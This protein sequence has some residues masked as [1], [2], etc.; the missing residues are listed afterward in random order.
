MAIINE[1]GDATINAYASGSYNI[2]EGDTFNGNLG[3]G[4]NEDGINLNGLN[5][6]TTYTISVT[7]DDLSGYTGLVLINRS[8]FH[9]VG[10][11]VS[12]GVPHT[13]IPGPRQR[14]CRSLQRDLRGNR[15]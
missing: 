14:R 3:S 13:G 5:P 8:D 6:G 1:A 4:D 9:S 7:V 10:M 11:H 2:V 12:A 15:S